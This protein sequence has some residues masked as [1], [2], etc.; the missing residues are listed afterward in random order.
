MKNLPR[1]SAIRQ[2]FILPNRSSRATQS[3]AAFMIVAGW[4]AILAAVIVAKYS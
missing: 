4:T 3:F 2:E 1:W